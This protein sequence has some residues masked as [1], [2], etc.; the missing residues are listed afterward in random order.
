MALVVQPAIAG[1][2]FDGTVGNGE[3][4]SGT[5][6]GNDPARMLIQSVGVS[7]SGNIL[8]VSVKMAPT[9]ADANGDLF[10]EILALSIAAPGVMKTGCAILVPSGWNIYFFSTDDGVPTKNAILDFRR[11]T[12]GATL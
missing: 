1:V 12:Y 10:L 8:T 2:N 5:V 4:L 9:L 11:I 6:A 7:A 3:F